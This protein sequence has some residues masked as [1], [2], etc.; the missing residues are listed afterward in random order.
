MTWRMDD[1]YRLCRKR[2]KKWNCL[3]N[4]LEER[5]LVTLVSSWFEHGA[6]VAV[7]DVWNLLKGKMDEK[8][9]E[10]IFLIKFFNFILF[11][12]S[13][14]IMQK[15]IKKYPGKLFTTNKNPGNF[16]CSKNIWK[17][18]YFFEKI[19]DIQKFSYLNLKSQKFHEIPS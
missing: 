19:S 3:E 2:E 12:I 14:K 18:F 6:C 17:I 15:K 1:V 8:F 9:Q 10:L 7:K 13:F 5:P 4:K 11:L 16:R